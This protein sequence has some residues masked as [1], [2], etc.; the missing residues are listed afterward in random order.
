[1]LYKLTQTCKRPHAPGC[2][3][4]IPAL[5][6]VGGGRTATKT[7]PHPQGAEEL[8]DSDISKV[9]QTCSY[10]LLEDD[11][12]VT[13]EMRLKPSGNAVSTVSEGLRQGGKLFQF[14]RSNLT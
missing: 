6:Q 4:G 5:P 2:N 8:G 10:I 3:H 13:K 14:P 7:P 9:R 1:M 11:L 12:S